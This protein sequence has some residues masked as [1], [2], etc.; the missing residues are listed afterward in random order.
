MWRI[1]I[2][3]AEGKKYEVEA[4][5]EFIWVNRGRG[6]LLVDGQVVDTW[7]SSVLGLPK[8]RVFEIA[9]RRAVLR[10]VGVINQNLELSVNAASVQRIK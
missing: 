9:G 4:R 8:E 10:S 6:E 7:R 2:V 3:E 5:Y 1:W